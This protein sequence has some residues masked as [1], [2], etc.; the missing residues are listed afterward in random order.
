MAQVLLDMHQANEARR[1]LLYWLRTMPRH[2][3]RWRLLAIA[4]QQCNR[5]MLARRALQRALRL[6]PDNIE[7]IGS[8]V[9]GGKVKIPD[10]GPGPF[11]LSIFRSGYTNA[12]QQ[13]SSSGSIQFPFN[14]N[15]GGK[16][17]FAE[18]ARDIS[19]LDLG[20][21]HDHLQK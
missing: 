4:H 12:G 8:S 2:S 10:P 20:T 7:A 15:V 9:F 1:L 3:E 6:D 17:L 19:P 13:V 11:L 14:H 5:P 21:G 16:F 18:K